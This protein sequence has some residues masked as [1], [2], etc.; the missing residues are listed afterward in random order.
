MN[1]QA[2]ALEGPDYRLSPLNAT[3]LTPNFYRGVESVTDEI[4]G[5][6]KIM[7]CK[8][9][10]VQRGNVSHSA[11]KPTWFERGAPIIPSTQVGSGTNNW[12]IRL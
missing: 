10:Q 2:A 1:D 4:F 8:E 12:W 11:V 5:L 7:L 3:A 6:C 9:R